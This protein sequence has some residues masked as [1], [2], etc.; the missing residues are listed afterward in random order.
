MDHE[1]CPSDDTTSLRLKVKQCIRGSE[2]LI[3]GLEISGE[4]KSWEEARMDITFYSDEGE[5]RPLAREYQLILRLHI[6][7][8]Y[9]A[10]YSKI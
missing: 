10:Q 2:L 5:S 9:S 4:Q 7:H 1:S 3:E 8:R 6:L